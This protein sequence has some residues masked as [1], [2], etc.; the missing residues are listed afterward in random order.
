MS[1]QPFSLTS[2]TK[3]SSQDA[4]TLNAFHQLFPR[5]G[6]TEKLRR[7]LCDYMA[8]QLG[9]AFS[10]ELEAM[11]LVSVKNSLSQRPPQGVYAILGMV[12]I[13]QRAVFELD[14][15]LGFMMID[16]TLGGE[17]KPPSTLRDLTEI[18]KGVLSYL[19]LKVIGLIFDRCGKSAKVHFRLEEVLSSM[20]SYVNHLSPQENGVE[21]LFRVRVSRYAGY[22]RLTLPLPL[23]YQAFLDPRQASPIE[24]EKDLEYDLARVRNFGFVQ[25]TLWAELGRTTLVGRE[26]VDLEPGD[27]VVLENSTAHVEQGVLKGSLSVRVGAGS[28]GEVLGEIVTNTDNTKCL[29]VKLMSVN[30][31][32]EVS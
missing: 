14:P 15:L 23:V 28:Q 6:F 25:T 3:I 11:N 8:N 31:K 2:L 20:E 9:V 16:K 17:A 30:Q 21:L 13:N 18:E 1:I 19:Y 29:A 4:E 12:P 22:A 32:H 27:V 26:V 10:L 5:I 24:N 7:S